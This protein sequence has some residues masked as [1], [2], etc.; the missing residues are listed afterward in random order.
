MNIFNKKIILSRNKLENIYSL[1]NVIFCDKG[2]NLF[3]IIILNIL[4]KKIPL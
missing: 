2:L 3:N 4:N 1:I